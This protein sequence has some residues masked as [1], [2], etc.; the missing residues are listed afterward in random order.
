MLQHA[1]HSQLIFTRDVGFSRGVTLYLTSGKV[2]ILC[3][4]PTHTR[5]RTRKRAEPCDSPMCVRRPTV[6]RDSQ[7][8]HETFRGK[9][10]PCVKS[11]KPPSV[12]FRSSCLPACKLN[13]DASYG[14]ETRSSILRPHRLWVSE[15]EVRRPWGQDGFVL[16]TEYH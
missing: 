11:G 13:T 3:P 14:C 4:L 9:S 15:N 1:V 8:I 10:L 16:F 2:C 5:A 12:Q 6:P 7:P